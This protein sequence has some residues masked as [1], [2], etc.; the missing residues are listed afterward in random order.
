MEWIYR[1]SLLITGLINILPSIL[2]FIPS[3]FSKSYGI[4]VT[5]ANLELL[6]RHRATFFGL[7]GGLLIFSAISKKL[8]EVSTFAGFFSMLSFVVLYFV[9]GKEMN[10]E[11]KKVMQIDV[12]AII[13]LFIGFIIY[14]LKVKPTV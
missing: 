1:A 12:A 8:Y 3:K 4:D 13:L 14:W 9:I 5:D 7:I 2:A 6:L 10:A 11:L